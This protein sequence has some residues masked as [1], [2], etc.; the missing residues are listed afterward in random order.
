MINWKKSKKK[1]KQ[2]NLVVNILG[3]ILSVQTAQVVTYKFS[4][5]I[6]GSQLKNM[7]ICWFIVPFIIASPK[8]T[9]LS[10]LNFCIFPLCMH[11]QHAECKCSV[12]SYSNTVYSSSNVL[13]GLLQASWCSWFLFCFK[14]FKITR[15]SL[16]ETNWR[17]QATWKLSPYLWVNIITIQQV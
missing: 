14:I 7:K 13:F 1:N 5:H 16:S 9:I 6:D 12:K 3:W 8:Y 4:I 10:L 15:I 2:Q 17:I 11:P